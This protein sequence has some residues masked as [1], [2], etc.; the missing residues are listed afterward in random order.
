MD[1]RLVNQYINQMADQLH[2]MQQE[3]LLLK[4]KLMIAN[5]ELHSYRQ[6]AQAEKS[7]F[8]KEQAE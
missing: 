5:E 8:S 4:S 7:D 6:A 3:N 1:E 2:K